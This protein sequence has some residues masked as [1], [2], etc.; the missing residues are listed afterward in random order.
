MLQ[1]GR[2]SCRGDGAVMVSGPVGMAFVCL[3]LAEEAAAIVWGRGDIGA[4]LGQRV[5]SGDAVVLFD[6]SGPQPYLTALGGVTVEGVPANGG[7]KMS[8]TT[9]IWA[10]PVNPAEWQVLEA[11]LGRP[12]E[13]GW[14]VSAQDRVRAGQVRIGRGFDEVEH[15]DSADVDVPVV[16]PATVFQESVDEPERSGQATVIDPEPLVAPAQAPVVQPVFAPEPQ[17]A[18]QPPVFAGPETESVEVPGDSGGFLWA[19][20]PGP[21]VDPEPEP[22]VPVNAFQAPLNAPSSAVEE[23]PAPLVPDFGSVNAGLPAQQVNPEAFEET[24][25]PEMFAQMNAANDAEAT[26]LRRVEGGVAAGPTAFLLY[27]GTAPI[28]VVR[29]VVIGRDPDERAIS[30]RPAA[31]VLRVLSPAT[32]ISRSHCAVMATAPGSWSLMDMGSAN[33]TLLRHADG[34]FQ[35]VSPMVMV[36]LS[37]GDLIDVGEGTTIEFRIR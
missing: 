34:S 32:E 9:D 36:P 30:G 21:V 35:E 26:I 3:P 15:F 27:G 22:L 17:Q 16:Q 2:F 12:G 28:E 8:W 11:T 19:P 23:D 37:D 24:M 29:D 31:T 14:S 25:T 10:W 5:H 6:V 1:I 7:E 20:E 18:S 33:G 13:D 4:W